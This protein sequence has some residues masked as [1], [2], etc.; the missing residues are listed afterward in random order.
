MIRRPW[1]A[2]LALFLGLLLVLLA[3]AEVLLW[4]TGLVRDP[5]EF[6]FQR[7]TRAVAED[8]E[9]RYASHPS[10]FYTIAANHRHGPEHLGRDAT[11]SWPFRGRPPEPAPV[12]MLR[13]VLVGD[14]CVYGASVDAADMLG[15]RVAAGFSAR[16]LGAD[17]VA[18]ISLGVPGYSTVQ[19]GLLLEEALD[20]LH[21]DA[22]VLYPAA[23]N[24]QAPALRRPDRELLA[25]LDDPSPLDWLRTR[26]R[27]GAALLH[28]LTDVSLKEVM[29]G[30]NAGDPPRG[31]RV[32]AGDVGPNV[33][34]MIARCAA[35]GTRCIVVSAAHPEQTLAEH[36]RTAQDAAAVLAA[37]RAA[38]V[39]ALDGQALLVATHKDLR[40]DFVD[41]VHPSPEGTA[42]LGPPI[43]DAVLAELLRPDADGAAGGALRG[44]GASGSGGASGAPPRVTSPAALAL[45]GDVSG[46]LSIVTVSPAVASVFGDEVLTL[47]LAGWTD[48]QPLPAVIVGGAPLIGLHAT[49]RDTLQGT[50]MANA[51]GLQDVV[52]QSARGCAVRAGALAR[53]QPQVRLHDVPGAPRELTITGRPGDRY[54]VFVAAA[55]RPLPEWTLRGANHLD[56]ATTLALPQV[57]VADEDGIARMPVPQL[58][59]GHASV[60]LLAVPRGEPDGVT[61]AARWTAPTDIEIRP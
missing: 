31:W 61:M 34:A 30:W 60:Q 46:G 12:G 47:T 3:L 7:V 24:D 36:P 18:V 41:Y 14:S 27:V 29:D 23:W 48:E 56:P 40:R 2:R 53:L 39:P 35:A 1:L 44:G 9:G 10:R 20:T 17:R 50:L 51:A 19:I 6:H 49:A 45:A 11:G 5:R 22:V 52:V 15:S 59:P 32:A 58:A 38:G 57:L 21:P 26:T 37:A 54:Q 43:A 16:G 55:L 4:A 28:E 8:P 33:A 13:V 25:E 42:I